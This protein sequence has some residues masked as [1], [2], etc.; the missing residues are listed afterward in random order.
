MNC[1]HTARREHA[2]HQSGDMWWM[3]MRAVGL[4]RPY[5]RLLLIARAAG[6]YYASLVHHLGLSMQR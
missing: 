6:K 4:T 5:D 1:L 3:I 2:A